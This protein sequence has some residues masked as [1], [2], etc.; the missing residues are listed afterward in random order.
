[1]VTTHVL[2]MVIVSCV[3]LIF[4]LDDPSPTLSQDT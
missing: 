3:G 2:I 1:L 4:L